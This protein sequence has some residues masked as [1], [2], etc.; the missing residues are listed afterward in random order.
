MV[1]QFGIV[2]IYTFPSFVTIG[3]WLLFGERP[4]R[5]QV[6][7]LVVSLAGCVLL[8][9]AYDPAVL[10]VSW[11]GLL[12][13]LSTGLTH[14]GYVLFSQRSVPRRS[15]RTSPATASATEGV[16]AVP[17]AGAGAAW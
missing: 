12:V 11:L 10:R 9:R 3:A 17:A 2:L 7:A 6:A 8:A 15:S 5:A 1:A 13:G 4:T 14:A 16:T